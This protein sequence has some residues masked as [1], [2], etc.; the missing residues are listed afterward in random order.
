MA[1]GRSRQIRRMFALIGHPVQKLRRVSIGGFTDSDLPL[2]SFRELSALEVRQ[3]RG[4]EGKGQS[5]RSRKKTP[6]R[7]T[8]ERA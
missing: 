7:K 3:L 8:T 4:K 2:G 1:E 6:A 5:S